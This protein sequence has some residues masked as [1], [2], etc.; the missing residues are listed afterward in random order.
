MLFFYMLNVHNEGRSI[1]GAALSIVGLGVR[2]LAMKKGKNSSKYAEEEICS[3]DENCETPS[4]KYGRAYF[5]CC[6]VN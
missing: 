1:Y 3:Y 2:I 5:I 6:N 4:A